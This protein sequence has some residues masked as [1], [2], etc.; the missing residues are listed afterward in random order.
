[1]TKDEELQQLRAEKAALRERLRQ[2]DDELKQAA[3]TNQTL[4]EG[5]TQ[6]IVAIERQQE[7]IK[8]LEGLVEALQERVKT[9]EGQQAKDSHNSSLPVRP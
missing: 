2:Q 9:L 1:M 4:R 3:Q 7:H 5:L 8:T 6:A